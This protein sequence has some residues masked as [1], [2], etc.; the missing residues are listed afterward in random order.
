MHALWFA[1]TTNPCSTGPTEIIKT[2]LWASKKVWPLKNVK[3]IL[4]IVAFAEWVT[5]LVDETKA[6]QDQQGWK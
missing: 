3:K 5:T 6:R 4:C 2:I 1:H